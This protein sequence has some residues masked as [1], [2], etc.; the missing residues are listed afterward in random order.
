MPFTKASM[1]KTKKY[2]FFSRLKQL[3]ELIRLLIH[4]R[5]IISVQTTPEREDI[6]RLPGGDSLY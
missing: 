6:L 3:N 5:S 1:L 2:R 4:K